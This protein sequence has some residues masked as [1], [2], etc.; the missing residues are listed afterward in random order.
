MCACAC[1][2]VHARARAH[3]VTLAWKRGSGPLVE[4]HGAGRGGCCSCR[5]FAGLSA[6][7]REH[8]AM[9]RSCI[10][11]AFFCA[12]WNM[13]ERGNSRAGGRAGGQPAGSRKEFWGRL[14]S[15]LPPPPLCSSGPCSLSLCLS[16][17][18]SLRLCSRLQVRAQWRRRAV[19]GGGAPGRRA[20]PTSRA[21]PSPQSRPGSAAVSRRP[22]AGGGGWRRAPPT[23]SAGRRP[24]APPAP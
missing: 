7:Q 12:K 19:A 13:R 14:L 16:L 6:G 15:L 2:C 10:G 17:S 1:V 5:E 24:A 18:L 23:R 20:W 11:R 8:A 21:R 9:M 3:A 22:A 4:Y